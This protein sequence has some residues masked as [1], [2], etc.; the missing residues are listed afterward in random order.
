MH[1]YSTDVADV[2][3]IDN[4]S[5]DGSLAYLTSLGEQVRTIVLDR[6]HGFAGGYNKGLAH[7]H[8][9]MV[10]LLN[11]DVE[12][13]PNWIEPM[14]SYLDSQ[15]AM[16]ACQPKIMDFVDRQRFEYAGAAGGYIDKD[17]F[18]FCAG[19]IFYQFENDE[20]QYAKNEEVFWASGAA[21]LIRKKAWNEVEGLDADFFAHMEEIDLCWRLKNRG[22]QIGACRQSIVYHVGGGTLDRLSPFK[23]YLNFRNNLY[24]LV[25]NYRTG[26]LFLKVIRRMLLD[27]IAGIRF[28]CEGK[29]GYFTAVIRAHFSFY[30]HL[31]LMLR[32]RKTENASL[33]HPNLS[34]LYRGSIIKHFFLHNKLFFRD[35]PRDLF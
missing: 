28:L 15:P 5:T 9:E 4:A 3:V 18:A 33:H 31:G 2:V 32:K 8:H 6:N 25:K 35:L 30:R 29:W 24:L 12:V 20:G 22:Y 26:S 27:G 23:T 11:S 17:G 1:A 19:R 34:G 13:T 16:V 7:I 10:L 21:L 14:V